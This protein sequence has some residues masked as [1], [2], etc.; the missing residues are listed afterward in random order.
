[1]FT[2]FSPLNNMKDCFL[3]FF[4]LLLILFCGESYA[5]EK[6]YLWV[7][8]DTTRS[9]MDTAADGSQAKYIQEYDSAKLERTLDSRYYLWTRALPISSTH[10]VSWHEHEVMPDTLF[11]KYSYAAYR[12]ELDASKKKYRTWQWMYYDDRDKP[13]SGLKINSER[14]VAWYPLTPPLKKLLRKIRS[15]AN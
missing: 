15:E 5:Q 6:Q 14:T 11:S 13:I 1:M 9:E 3:F 4:I 2:T 10:K 7:A 8:Y 12:I